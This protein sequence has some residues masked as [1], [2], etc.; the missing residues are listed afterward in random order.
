MEDSPTP[1]ELLR[2]P[3]YNQ[4]KGDIEE[5]SCLDP[6]FCQDVLFPQYLPAPKIQPEMD[7]CV[8][9]N[10]IE[11]LSAIETN[12]SW[13]LKLPHAKFWCQAVNNASLQVFLD[14]YLKQTPRF[15]T[16]SWPDEVLEKHNAV[17]RL[18]FMTYLRMATNKESSSH[19]I[20]SDFF[21][22][23]LYENYL[24]DI[25]KIMDLC[26]IYGNETNSALLGKAISNIFKFQ[27]SYNEDL[28]ETV[29]TIMQVFHNID[30]KC[31]VEY[32][33]DRSPN[34]NASSARRPHR[35]SEG[36]SSGRTELL[37]NTPLNEFE[38]IIMYTSDVSFTLCRFL[39]DVYPSACSAFYENVK[40]IAHFY[41]NSLSILNEAALKYPLDDLHL[42]SQ[43]LA[44]LKVSRKSLLNV[45]RQI[46]NECLLT[47]ALNASEVGD[48][49]RT[50][51]LAD[52]YFH[53]LSDLLGE[54][55]FFQDFL[56]KLPIIDDVQSLLQ[57]SPGIDE[58]RASFILGS[59]GNGRKSK[60]STPSTILLNG[61]AEESPQANANPEDAKEVFKAASNLSTES[62]V[63]MESLISTV[64][65]VLP[66]LGEGYIESCL[67]YYERDCEKTIHALLEG[68]LPDDLRAMDNST[69]R[70]KRQ[71][72][73]SPVN[74]IKQTNLDNQQSPYDISSLE[75][76]IG[77]NE[78][79]NVF[80]GDDFDVYQNSTIDHSKI[81]KGKKTKDHEPAPAR[82][83][84]MRQ[85]YEKYSIVCDEEEITDDMGSLVVDDAYCNM[86]DDEYDDMYDGLGV[87]ANDVDDADD[88]LKRR[89]FVTPR[90]FLQSKKNEESGSNG[91]EE[92]EEEKGPKPD[93]F[94]ANPA[95]VRAKQDER[96]R[97][98]QELRNNRRGPKKGQN[99]SSSVSSNNPNGQQNRK[100][101]DMNKAKVANHNRKKMATKKAAKGMI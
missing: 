72:S 7:P 19:F 89:P 28:K 51:N 63:E 78:R 33:P 22:E 84:E 56:R 11:S 100:K 39:V 82:T 88:L 60:Y 8:W 48:H 83:T 69:P 71:Y 32:H 38:D 55:K 42:R 47:P 34:E 97:Q 15:Q 43:L 16:S 30:E 20:T 66:H 23:L 58:T 21:G 10:W 4:S 1:L 90:V 79:K 70:Q 44:H 18:V 35:L 14:S 73:A 13:L 50:N 87:D 85:I 3:Y 61:T 46:L 93:H 40:Y 67:L 75:E 5:L 65:D 95:D 17:H 99:P 52:D 59:L 98:Q 36:P 41:S 24:F 12:L 9:Q 62:D 80:D 49:S 45:I 31:G 2:F 25:P 74:E 64:H 101:K 77:L 26:A 92:S 91:S 57:A 68:N 81:H 94:I 53:I 27:P 96:R 54:T 86:Y 76:T 37:I 6:K 29:G